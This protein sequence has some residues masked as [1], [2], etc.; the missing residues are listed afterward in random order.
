MLGSLDLDDSARTQVDRR[1]DRDVVKVTVRRDDGQRAG[2][3]SLF[4]FLIL[5]LR[6]RWFVFFGRSGLLGSRCG[7][8]LGGEQLDADDVFAEI[9]AG[10]EAPSVFFRSSCIAPLASLTASFVC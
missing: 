3:F 5:R 6:L 10:V 7:R 9:R 1:K 2:P 8:L 4:L